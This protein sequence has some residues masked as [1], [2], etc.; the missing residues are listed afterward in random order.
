[1]SAKTGMY[2]V[3]YIRLLR[4]KKM[5]D[6]KSDNPRMTAAEYEPLYRAEVRKNEKYLRAI[7]DLV[8]ALNETIQFIAEESG[9]E[10]I[11]FSVQEILDQA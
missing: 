9:Q 1:M 3:T 6:Y 2:A 4:R 5:A 7:K 10:P 8:G 11:V